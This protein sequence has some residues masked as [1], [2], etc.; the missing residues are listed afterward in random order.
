MV[1]K[2]IALIKVSIKDGFA[3]LNFTQGNLYCLHCPSKIYYLTLEE[4][5]RKNW[6]ECT[7]NKFWNTSLYII[8][9]KYVRSGCI[10][11]FIIL[12]PC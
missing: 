3:I 2:L 10:F 7:L 4:K 8:S 9:V 11:L 12:G 6:S 1:L 5:M